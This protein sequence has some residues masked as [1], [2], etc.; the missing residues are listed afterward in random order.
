MAML[1]Q[2]DHM[3]RFRLV[4]QRAAVRLEKLGMKRRGPSVTSLIKKQYSLPMRCSYD[5]VL[6]RLQEEIDKVGGD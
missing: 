1:T 4:S 5:T 2:T 6:A 3:I